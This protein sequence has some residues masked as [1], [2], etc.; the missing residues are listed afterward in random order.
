MLLSV[1]AMLAGDRKNTQRVEIGSKN[2][3]LPPKDS[4]LGNP[5]RREG[6]TEEA[7]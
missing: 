2:F 3:Q 5:D 1:V 6:T 4:I 7:G